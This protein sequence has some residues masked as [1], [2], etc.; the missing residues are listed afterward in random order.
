M[1]LMINDIIDGKLSLQKI[2]RLTKEDQVIILSQLYNLYD[3]SKNK[4]DKLKYCLIIF[5]LKEIFLNKDY[6]SIKNSV[7]YKF[8]KEDKK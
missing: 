1:K 7:L 4:A 2:K 3:S 6:R 5:N 8:I